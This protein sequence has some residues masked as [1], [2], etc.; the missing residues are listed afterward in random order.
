MW[1]FTLVW[2]FDAEAG[3]RGQHVYDMMLLHRVSD[4]LQHFTSFTA[5]ISAL[6]EY[7]SYSYTFQVAA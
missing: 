2:L 4:I 5:G 3:R 7:R 1:Y 6:R